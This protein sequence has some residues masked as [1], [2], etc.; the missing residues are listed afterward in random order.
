LSAEKE[1]REKKETNPEQMSEPDRSSI[2]LRPLPIR[3]TRLIAQNLPYVPP[4]RMLRF[5]TGNLSEGRE[6]RCE[7]DRPEPGEDVEGIQEGD[8]VA[9][10]AREGQRDRRKGER[11]E[12]SRRTR[13]IG[14]GA[15]RRRR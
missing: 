9:S 15:R 6:V 10:E 7:V 12:K 2:L 8:G 14:R 3:H 13:R 5:R 11:D 1:G 4:E